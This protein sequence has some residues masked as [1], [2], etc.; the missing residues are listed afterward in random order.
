[1]E[2]DQIMRYQHE[3]D[4]ILDQKINHPALSLRLNFLKQSIQVLEH[5]SFLV[6]LQQVIAQFNDA[7]STYNKMVDLYNR[8]LDKK[9]SA[10][11]LQEAVNQLEI[12]FDAFNKLGQAP[13]SL[14]NEQQMLAK[15]LK[16][17]QK[18][19]MDFEKR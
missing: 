2:M 18:N 5:N 19:I 3:L 15:N 17:L 6:A 10:H 16:T 12:A 13:I 14:R 9:E 11:L 8:K 7:V 4:R 1:M